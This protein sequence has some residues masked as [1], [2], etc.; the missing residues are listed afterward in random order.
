MMTTKRKPVVLIPADVKQLGEHPFHVAGHKYIMAVAEAAGAL[1]LV[2]PAISD[3]LDI[4]VL[5][6][7]A[8]GILLTGAVSNVHPSHFGQTVHNPSLPLD[9][10]RD[11]LTLKLVQAA[12]NAEVP[13]L[14]ICR[15]FQEINVA[16][17]GSLHQAVHEVS[18]LNDH[19]EAKESTLDIQYGESHLIDLVASGQLAQIVG[20]KQMMVNS[21][22]GQGIDKLGAG[23]VAE[24]FASDGLVEALRVE[25]AKAFTLGVQWHPEWKV[26]EN[27]Q[28]LAI[29][30]A[31]GD[32]CR[33]RM[34]RH[35]PPD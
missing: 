16:F 22:H 32:A 33:L 4:D 3:L 31:F 13:L 28:Y 34:R 2:V 17:G 6:A 35:E 7:M 18:G 9:P 30:K 19:R 26:M 5:L 14:A 24:A 25:H 11:A 15:G 27:P 20:A 21:I 8:D 29:F 12:I 1:P 10:A 23:L